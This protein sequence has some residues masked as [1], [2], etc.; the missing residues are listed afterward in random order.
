M[1]EIIN[2]RRTG[3]LTLDAERYCV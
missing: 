1:K 2:G 3:R